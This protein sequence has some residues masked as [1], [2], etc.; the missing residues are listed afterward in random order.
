MSKEVKI[1]VLGSSGAI[2]Q[3]LTKELFKSGYQVTGTYYENKPSNTLADYMYFNAGAKM[4]DEDIL[5]VVEKSDLIINLMYS[6]RRDYLDK[7]FF[8]S[9]FEVALRAKESNSRFINIDDLCY[10]INI[11]TSISKT[12]NR[13]R[14]VIR[15]KQLGINI[16]SASVIS[17][18]NSVVKDISLLSEYKITPTLG[19]GRRKITPIHI[20]DFCTI[21]KRLIKSDIR[22]GVYDLKGGLSMTV[23]HLFNVV[24]K[25]NS[26]PEP[27]FFNI[28]EEYF[29]KYKGIINNIFGTKLTERVL[30][31][32]KAKESYTE[33]DLSEALNVKPLSL[34]ARVKRR[35]L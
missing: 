25:A 23:R 33:K 16:S 18:K 27:F 17:G 20:V 22:K 26:R 24:C 34:E 11:P 7:L 31:I 14:E 4:I 6:D 21:I 12:R 10:S 29:V 19:D 9:P 5:G 1:L 8:D 32:L 15:E 30:T 2:G 3:A 13:F 28:P 35:G